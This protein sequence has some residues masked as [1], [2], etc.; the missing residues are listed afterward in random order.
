MTAFPSPETLPVL[1]IG[2]VVLRADTRDV[3]IVQ[4]VPKRVGEVPAYVMPR[5]SRQYLHEDAWHDARDAATGLQ[6]QATLE[7]FERGLLREIEE[8]AGV[9]QAQVAQAQ[10]RDIGVR[11]FQSRSKGVYP[12]YWFVVVLDARAAGDVV[13]RTPVDALHTCWA[14]L[15]EIQKMANRGEFSS[16]YLPIIEEAL[17][18][19]AGAL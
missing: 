9:T 14:G 16:G 6:H 17:D 8:E 11:Y 1:K 18:R 10:V 3:L 12:I 15:N 2:A 19:V 7:P 4:P 5:G 13:T